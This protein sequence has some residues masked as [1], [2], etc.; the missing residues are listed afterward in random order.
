MVLICEVLSNPG[1]K[2][3]YFSP[4]SRSPS[5]YWNRK[6]F[7][8]PVITVLDERSAG[9]IALGKVNSR[10]SQW[11]HCT[12]VRSHS[13]VSCH[14]GSIPCRTPLLL[15]PRTAN[16]HNCGAG[17]TIYQENIFEVSFDNFINWM[18]RNQ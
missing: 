8:Y 11:A 2:T 3:I 7:E 1:L 9:F 12:S 13:L 10:M 15:S 17:Q 16:L 14:H 5:N 4:G 6:M 18:F